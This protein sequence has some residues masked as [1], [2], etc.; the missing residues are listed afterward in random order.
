MAADLME[1]VKRYKLKNE[2]DIKQYFL[3][4]YTGKGQDEES[5]NK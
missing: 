2:D 4:Y 3:R 5:E 1:F